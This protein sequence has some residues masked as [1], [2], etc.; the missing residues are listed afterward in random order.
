[1]S[2]VLVTGG[3]GFIGSHVVE[4]LML[5]QHEVTVLD[6]LSTG[7]LSNLD[8]L[9]C[10]FIYGSILDEEKLQE[11]SRGMD[12]VIHLAA[13]VS[14]PESFK[15]PLKCSEVN[16]TG[17]LNVLNA[18]KKNG[19]RRFIQ[20]S[21]SA[22]YGDEPSLPKT[23]ESPLVPMSPYAASKLAAEQL[24]FSYSNSG[25]S[26]TSLRFFNVYGQRQDPSSAYSGVISIFVSRISSGLPI[27]VFG[28]GG[29]TRDFICVSDVSTY[30]V[31]GLRR[32]PDTHEILN[33]A[34]GRSISLLEMVSFIADA[35]GNSVEITFAEPRTGDIYHSSASVSK[36][37]AIDPHVTL[38]FEKGIATLV[39]PVSNQ[40]CLS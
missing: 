36:L 15:A 8:G 17:T 32:N 21:S 24:A 7:K 13:I 29:Q 3:A 16:V 14:V 18:C 26:C 31:N 38:P 9:D 4:Q 6:D 28:D 33:I 19:I 39:C 27:T 37:L 25:I 11:V 34:T 12:A 22:V 30:V 1:M 10:S 20:A 2:R 35:S 5:N 40:F 23:E